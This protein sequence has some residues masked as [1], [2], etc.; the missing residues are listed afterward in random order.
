MALWLF[1]S[2][3][4]PLLCSLANS[5]RAEQYFP[6]L[7]IGIEQVGVLMQARK[8][9]AN[10]MYAVGGVCENVIFRKFKMA[11]FFFQTDI[12]SPNGNFVKHTCP[13]ICVKFEV[14]W[15]YGVCCTA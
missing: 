4:P 11:E 2:R 3:A 10:R 5:F 15:S 12:R 6:N 13:H 1:I 14:I 8:F 7:L 9:R